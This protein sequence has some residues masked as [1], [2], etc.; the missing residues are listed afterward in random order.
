[1]VERRPF[2]IVLPVAGGGI[3]RGCHFAGRLAL[4]SLPVQEQR[5][6]DGAAR[7]ACRVAHDVGGLRPISVCFAQRGTSELVELLVPVCHR[8]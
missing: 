5:S 4:S 8:V 6:V 3:V 1:M 7:Q 2:A